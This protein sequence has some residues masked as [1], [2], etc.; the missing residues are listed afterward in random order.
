MKRSKRLV[1][2]LEKRVELL[3][4]AM[5]GMNEQIQDLKN[6]LIEGVGLI[7]VKLEEV[8]KWKK[9]YTLAV[10]VIGKQKKPI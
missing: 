9:K 7:L 10:Y 4:D 5:F 6:L 8:K 1:P 3:A 2:E